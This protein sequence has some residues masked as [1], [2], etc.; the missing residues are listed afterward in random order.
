MFRIESQR[1]DQTLA[2]DAIRGKLQ[3]SSQAP[4]GRPMNVASVALSGLGFFFDLFPGFR[5]LPP[6]W[7]NV[8]SPLWGSVRKIIFLSSIMAIDA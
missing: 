7:A 3:S 2:P 8:C 5:L 4:A 1:D 6:P